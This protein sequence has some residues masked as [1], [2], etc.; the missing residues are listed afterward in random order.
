MLEGGQS[1][2]YFDLYFSKCGEVESNCGEKNSICGEKNSICGE[3]LANEIQFI[4]LFAG[5]DFL[6]AGRPKSIC[7]EMRKRLPASTKTPRT[8]LILNG[9]K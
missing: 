5:R 6:N 1:N 2:R 3:K 7:G 4:I 8:P 9:L